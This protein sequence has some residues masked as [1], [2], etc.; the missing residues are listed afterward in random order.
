MP[1]DEYAG[2]EGARAADGT[3]TLRLSGE[4]D[5]ASVDAVAAGIAP[6]LDGASGRVVFDLADLQFMDSTGLAL[7]VR[8]ANRFDAASITNA[9]PNVLR[10][11]EVSG[12]ADVF[13]L[14]T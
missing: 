9:A 1:T 3:L 2:V 5:I 8:T 6:L 13:E 11:L 14:T 4:I 12:L 10:V 7:L